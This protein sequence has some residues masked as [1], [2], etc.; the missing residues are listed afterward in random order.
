MPHIDVK[1]IGN[2]TDKE[3][4]RVAERIAEV[5]EEELGK[6]KKYISVSIEGKTFADWENVYNSEIKDNANIV[7]KPGYTNPKTFQ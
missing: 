5:I 6:P 3:K 4:N 2:P 7:M 1:L